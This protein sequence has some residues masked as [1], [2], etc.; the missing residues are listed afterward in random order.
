MGD[1]EPHKSINGFSTPQMANWI[2]IKGN[3]LLQFK[4]VYVRMKIIQI[5]DTKYNDYNN[6]LFSVLKIGYK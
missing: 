1:K 3:A 6:V 2:C 5:I 4:N